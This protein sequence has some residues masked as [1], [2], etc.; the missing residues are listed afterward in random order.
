MENRLTIPVNPNYDLSMD[1]GEQDTS[2]VNPVTLNNMLI[3]YANSAAKIVQNITVARRE[4]LE[5]NLKIRAAKQKFEDLEYD[6]LQETPKASKQTLKI[7]EAEI[8]RKAKEI[9]NYEYFAGLEKELHQL[10]D[11]KLTLDV[12][13]ENYESSLDL[14]EQLSRDVQTHLSFIKTEMR[15]SRNY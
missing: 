1:P 3:H 5:V 9:G 12:K 14:I 13:I 6:L 11:Q 4:R 10:Q 7:Q 15:Q 2:Y 8:R